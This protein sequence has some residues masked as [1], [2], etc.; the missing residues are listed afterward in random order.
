MMTTSARASDHVLTGSID[1]GRLR[2]LY[3]RPGAWLLLLCFLLPCLGLLTWHA[4]PAQAQQPSAVGKAQEQYQ[5]GLRLFEEAQYREA[6]AAFL[7]AKRLARRQDIQRSIAQAYRLLR[8]YPRA[9]AASQ[10][11]LREFG[12]EMS[13]QERA[14]VQREINELSLLTGTVR[15]AITEPGASVAIDGETVGT[16]PLT[17]P[18]RLRLGRHTIEVSKPGFHP[19]RQVVELL[20]NEQTV[21]SG[22]LEPIAT[23]GGWRWW[24][25]A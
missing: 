9:L 13:D 6:L 2:V 10:E 23:T 20:E 4:G 21:V 8:D 14:E 7:A 3:S 1:A 17:A 12:A 15:I 5:I 25:G 16:T 19:L 24:C 22:K 11:L 18:V